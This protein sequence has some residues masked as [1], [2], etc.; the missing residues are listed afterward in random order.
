MAK[1]MKANLSNDGLGPKLS[2]IYWAAPQ[3]CIGRL[4]GVSAAFAATRCMTG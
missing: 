1:I 2:A 3:R 4:L